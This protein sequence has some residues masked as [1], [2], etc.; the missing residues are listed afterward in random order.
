LCHLP[1][2][3]AAF[4]FAL[5]QALLVWAIAQALHTRRWYLKV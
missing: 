3:D 2:A 1:P 5:L 4:L